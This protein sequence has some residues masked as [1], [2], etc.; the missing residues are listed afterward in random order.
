MIAPRKLSKIVK[1]TLQGLPLAGAA[2]SVFLPISQV[3]HQ[4]MMLIVLVW[5][6]VFFILDVFVI[7]K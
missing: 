4:F 2:S 6:Q 7:G 1:Y 5:L 3:A